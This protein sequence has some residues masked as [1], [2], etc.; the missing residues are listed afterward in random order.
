MRMQTPRIVVLDGITANP[1]DLDWNEL[2]ALGALT[3]HDRTPPGEVI[4]RAQGADVVLTNK[5][6]LSAETLGRLP[7]LRCICVLATGYNVVDVAA[8]RSR[9][10][11][12]CNVPGYS[13]PSVVQHALSLLLELTNQVGLHNRLV[14]EG[15]WSA[16]ADFAFWR[17]PLIELHGRTLGIIGFGAIGRG[18]ADAARPLGMRLL[19]HG[20]RRPAEL[21]ADVEWAAELDPLLRAADVVSLHCPLTPETRH[22]I[23]ERTLARLKPSALLINTGRGPLVDEQA[24]AAALR[25]GRLAGAAVDVLSSEPPPADHPLLGVPNCI[26]TPHHAWATVAARRRLLAESAANV[27]GFLTGSP[28][29]VVN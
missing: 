7:A 2:A 21:P 12:V 24:L 14:H 10:I 27:R 15:A 4:A 22:L 18:L 5:T 20:R 6:I 29:N 17:R 1:G 16:C 19:A 3:V 8:A 23:N 25:D 28:R 11:T 26:I 9:G 13:T